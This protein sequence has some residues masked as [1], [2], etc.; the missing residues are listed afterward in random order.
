[1]QL[2]ITDLPSSKPKTARGNSSSVSTMASTR[3]G[4]NSIFD[5]GKTCI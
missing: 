2:L 4:I 1:M 3:F 5:G